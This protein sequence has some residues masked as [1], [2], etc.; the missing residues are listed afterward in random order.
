MCF[1]IYLF[2]VYKNTLNRKITRSLKHVRNYLKRIILLK[3]SN[4]VT[5]ITKN[6]KKNNKNINKRNIFNY[7]NKCFFEIIA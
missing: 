4:Y 1:L 2:F 6:Q 7:L 3:K 5:I